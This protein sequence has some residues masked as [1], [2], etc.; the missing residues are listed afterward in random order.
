MGG[1]TSEPLDTAYYGHPFPAPSDPIERRRTVLVFGFITSPLTN[2]LKPLG[3]S[4]IILLAMPLT[5]TC[6]ITEPREGK[7]R[8]GGGRGRGREVARAEQERR[9]HVP[10]CAA[11]KP[12]C[13]SLPSQR[14]L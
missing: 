10:L 8:V 5:Q 14:S 2:P 1:I 7:E 13:F 12:P 11:S 6:L 4:S 9:R 3:G